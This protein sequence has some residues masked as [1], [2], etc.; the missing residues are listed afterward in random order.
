MIQ[1]EPVVPGHYRL[2]DESWAEITEAF[3][4]GATARELA[5]KWRVSMGSVY[6]HARRAGIGKKT[7]GDELARA[8]ARGVEAREPTRGP[9]DWQTHKDQIAALFCDAGTDPEGTPDPAILARQATTASGRAM[10]EGLWSE[11][12]AL[13][14]LAE[15]YARLAERMGGTAYDAERLPL[16]TLLAVLENRDELIKRRCNFDPMGPYDAETEMKKQYLRR[17]VGNHREEGYPEIM[18]EAVVR[19]MLNAGPPQPSKWPDW[20]EGEK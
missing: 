11:A 16:Q 13:S 9:I 5:V 14:A 10:R 19:D 12:K 15:S 17:V 6:G 2:S 3:K 4:N 20:K 7:T 1:R 8:H 18:V